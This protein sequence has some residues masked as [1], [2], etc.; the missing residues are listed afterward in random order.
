MVTTWVGLLQKKLAL[1]N[2]TVKTQSTVTSSASVMTV[3]SNMEQAVCPVTLV[4]LPELN[5]A[6]VS[7]IDELIFSRFH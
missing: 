6:K 5:S 2:G 3:G 7:F 4:L 1:A